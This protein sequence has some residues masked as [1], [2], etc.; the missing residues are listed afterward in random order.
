[1]IRERIRGPALAGLLAVM[2]AAGGCA[3]STRAP[4]IEK[5]GFMGADFA[6]LKPGSEG[7]AQLAYVRPGVNWSAYKFALLDPVTVWKGKESAGKGISAADEQILVNYFYSVIRDALEKEG[8]TIV[9]APGPDTLRVKV[10][11][12]KPEESNVTLNVVSTVIPALHV[13]SS[14]DKLATGKPAFVG[15]AQVEVKATDALTGELLA[16]GIDHRVGGKALDASMMTSWGDV[17]AM[18]RL[19]A[20][21]GSYNLCRLQ[22]RTNC[23]APKPQQ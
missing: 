9:N 1:M 10:A 8:F 23:I 22:N 5:S 2:V 14:L 6:L 15:E 17:E 4:D 19:W 21:H 16:A 13:A 18:M 20:S 3:T 7:H 12:T 11:I